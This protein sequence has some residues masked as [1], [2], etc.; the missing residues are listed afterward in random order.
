MRVLLLLLLFSSGSNTLTP[1]RQWDLPL[2][3]S[4]EDSCFVMV[5]KNE[6]ITWAQQITTVSKV[7]VWNMLSLMAMNIWEIHCCEIIYL[8]CRKQPIKSEKL[9]PVFAFKMYS[10]ALGWT[11]WPRDTWFTHKRLHIPYSD[12]CVLGSG[13]TGAWHIIFLFKCWYKDRQ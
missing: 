6:P 1:T 9:R 11:C 7:S 13:L 5:S 10:V 12:I 4:Q 3:V 2:F 8:V